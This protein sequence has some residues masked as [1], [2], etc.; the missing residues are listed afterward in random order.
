MISTSKSICKISYQQKISLG[1]LIKLF[2]KD[3]DFFCLMTNCHIITKEMI[4]KREKICFYYDND[5]VVKE[6]IL[7][8][9]ERYIKEFSDISIDVIVVEILPTD[10]IDKNYF[11]LP[12]IN[13]IYE[14]KDLKNK[15]IIL[16]KNQY[17]IDTKIKKINNYEFTYYN[18]IESNLSG[19]PIFLKDNTKVIGINKNNLNNSENY[20]DFIG[21]IFNYFKNLEP[22][23]K[24]V[25]KPIDDDFTEDTTDLIIEPSFENEIKFIENT[26]ENIDEQN[27]GKFINGKLE[28]NGKYIWENGQ[29][30]IGQ[31][32]NGKK[33]GKGIIYYKD[34]TIMYEGDFINDKK[35]GNGK[36]IWKNGKYYIGEWKNNK[37]N[38]KGKDY[39]SN[40]NILYEGDY[41]N[42]KLDGNGKL[43]LNIGDYYI[44]QFK[45]GKRN[46]KGIIYYKNGN[47]K[48]S[49]NID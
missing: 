32:K 13:Y 1:F 11:L 26:V 14:Y 15:E 18:D 49:T 27:E 29:Y 7:N 31:W 33:H 40:G 12:D 22:I 36:F 37:K 48:C 20:A 38:G 23:K 46:G 30:Y 17:Y 43:I 10:N 39:F 42:G 47:I 41:I 4:K 45:N 28:G 9:N 16:L 24:N 34:G 2:K 8:S 19:S 3:K 5:Q 44:G 25:N 6:I 21:P 35:E